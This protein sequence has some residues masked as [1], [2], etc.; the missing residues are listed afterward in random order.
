MNQVDYKKKYDEALERMKSWARGEHPE[1]FTEARKAAEFIFPELAESEDESIRKGIIEYL[2]QSQ[3]GEEHYQIDDDIVRNYISWLEK[4]KEQLKI[5][6]DM[7]TTFRNSVPEE[8]DFSKDKDLKEE[9]D[10]CFHNGMFPKYITQYTTITVS[11]LM[12]CASHF[13]KFGKEHK[14]ISLSEEDIAN[15]DN[16]IWLCENSEKGTEITWLP[17]QAREIKKLMETIKQHKE[18]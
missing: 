16:I 7:L 14:P 4:Q 9:V 5:K 8:W 3:F 1:C 15:I 2:E 18:L 12:R 6:Q 10:R 11:D 13:Y 17:T